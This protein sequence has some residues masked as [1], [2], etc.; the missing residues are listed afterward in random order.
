MQKSASIQP[1]TS[2]IKF[3]HLA[4]KSEKGSISNLSTKEGTPADGVPFPSHAAQSTA[5]GVTYS[6]SEPGYTGAEREHPKPPSIA[7]T[8]SVAAQTLVES[9]DIEPYSD[10][11]AK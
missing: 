4:E 10:F 9:F 7:D 5:S 6:S 3:G 11:S 1:R 8:V 2:P